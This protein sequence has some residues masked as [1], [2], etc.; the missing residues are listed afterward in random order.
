MA[1]KQGVSLYS[2]QDAYGRGG[3]G[4]NGVLDV[5]VASGATGVEILSDQ[6]VRGAANATDETIDAVNASL[7]RSGLERVSNDIFINSSL[8]KN[9]WLTIEE[10]A[11]ALSADLRLT[12]R[13]GFHLVRVVSQT[14]PAV[15][16]LVL[17]LAE[18]LDVALAV[19][20]HAGMS[21]DHPLT[22]AWIEEMK[23]VGSPLVG[24]VVDLGIYC[25][26]HP[27]VATRYF[28]EELGVNDEVVRYIDGI[29][30]QG[31]DPRQFFPRNPDNPDEYE[32]PEELTRHFKHFQDRFYA[33]MSTG[34]ENTS[35]DT[36]NEYAPYIKS[37]HGKFWEVTDE[38]E[39]YSIDYGRV[40]ARLNEIGWDG[41][42]CSEYEGQR[43]ALP[44]ERI[45][46]IE[47]VNRHQD[48]MARH[49]RDGLEGE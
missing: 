27:R 20:V 6:M 29:F 31:I 11:E 47:Q 5:A 42:V 49:L 23:A 44:G 17:P 45:V 38:G 48:M 18:K 14:D 33:M 30:E 2:L 4:L 19:E 40:F 26:R 24:L 13:L 8:Y 10:Q 12:N 43:F 46:D 3:L 39:E 21:F 32:F 34:Y 28:Q 41:Y 15:I 1:I 16:R 35:L 37:I 36:L 7:D 9:R 25:Q 22:A